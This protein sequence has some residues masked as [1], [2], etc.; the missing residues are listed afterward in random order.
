MPDADARPDPSI[1]FERPEC[2][3][4]T[5]ERLARLFC[6]AGVGGGPSNFYGWRGDLPATIGLW[7]ARRDPARCH[8]LTEMTARLA[9]TMAPLL[10]RPFALFGHSM[11]GLIAYELARSLEAAGMPV[12]TRLFVAAAR[13]PRE[14]CP[15]PP[16]HALPSAAFWQAMDGPGSPSDPAVRAEL[17]PVLR[18]DLRLLEC[19]RPG[20]PP[21]L[22]CPISVF[23]GRED[24]LLPLEDLALWDGLS[25]AGCS[26]EVL[27]GGHAFPFDPGAGATL[28]QRIVQDLARG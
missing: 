12:P 11:G 1:W 17:E 15:G 18:A 23:G 24:T 3:E 16:A 6:F 21:A 14:P 5:D 20:T 19:Y 25:R 26:I 22:A 4:P 8:D 13:S 7:L 28:R 10:D 27:D 2:S 9:G